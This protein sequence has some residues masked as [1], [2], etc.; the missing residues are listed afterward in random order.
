VLDKIEEMVW[1]KKASG[2][3]KGNIIPSRNP[4]P[5]VNNSHNK[6]DVR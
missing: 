5:F 1:G 6:E 3:W 4:L 2:G